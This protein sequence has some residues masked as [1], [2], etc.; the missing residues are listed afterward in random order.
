MINIYKNLL[1]IVTEYRD[2]NRIGSLVIMNNVLPDS[3]M[4][5]MG[6]EKDGD[7]FTLNK[8]ESLSNQDKWSIE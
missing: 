6:F 7:Y 8:K 5:S 4:I 3:F 1:D 2:T